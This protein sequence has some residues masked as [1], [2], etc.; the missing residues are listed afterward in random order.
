MANLL[1]MRVKFSYKM[2]LSLL[3]KKVLMK[4][5][6]IFVILVLGS[7][8]AN[9]QSISV[10]DPVMIQVEDTYYLFCTGRGIAVWSSQDMQ[11]WKREKAVFEEPPAWTKEVVP[12]F[13]NHIWAPDISYHKGQYYLY[14]SISSFAKNTSAIGVA[15]N[16]TLDPASP[17]FKWVDH[18][19]VIQS[20]PGR[21]MWNAIDPNI[22][23][24]EEETAWMSFGSFWGGLKL[25]KLAEDMRSV[26]NGPED[27]YTIARRERSFDLDERDPGDAALEAPFIF[28]KNGYYYLF[29]SYDLCCRGDKSTY[30]MVVGRSKTVQ[31]PYLD[32]EG[33][34]LY[35]GF[36][37]LILEGNENWYGVGHNSAYTFDGKDYLIFHGYDAQENGRPKLITKEIQWDNDWPVV[38][39]MK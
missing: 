6:I 15:T 30:K 12:D 11:N 22:I 25:V 9:A 3:I 1:F 16:T 36:G 4:Q 37:T 34:S 21:D 20:V 5:V 17:D 7:F 29:V 10:H 32:R 2:L 18:G 26:Q 19:K 28:K 35:S 39:P 8:C 27:W 31:G 23:F 33:N 14:Y 24:D 13:R 38:E